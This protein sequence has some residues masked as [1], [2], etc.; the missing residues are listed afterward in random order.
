MAITSRN[1]QANTG[2]IHRNQSNPTI[3]TTPPGPN[4]IRS[5]SLSTR[6]CCV[7]GHRMVSRWRD[8]TPPHTVTV[9]DSIRA[10]HFGTSSHRDGGKLVQV[11]YLVDG[12]YERVPA[13]RPSWRMPVSCVW[14]RDSPPPAEA[15]APSLGDWASF[16][17]SS[18][19][20]ERV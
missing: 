3:P 7:F 14:N 20:A 13:R 11:E 2:P 18:E 10:Q 6:G 16:S 1:Q 5:S 17:E 19:I 15:G 12:V 8:T 4:S 9:P